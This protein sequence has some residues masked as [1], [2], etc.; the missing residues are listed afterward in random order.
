MRKVV[1]VVLSLALI[2]AA[3]AVFA[4]QPPAG[5]PSGPGQNRFGGGMIGGMMMAC[6]AMAIAPPAAAMIERATNLNLTDDQKTK[7]TEKLTKADATLAPLRQ[8]A[9][10]AATALRTA[11]YAATFDAAKVQ[12]LLTAAQQADAAVST[13]ELAVWTELRAILTADQI[14]QLQQQR[15]GG[16][17][18]G[19]Q[20][21]PGQGQPGQGQPGGRTRGNRNRN[22]QPT[23]GGNGGGG[24]APAQ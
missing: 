24:N 18:G 13:A 9:S 12:T 6:P 16:F 10:E 19:Y 21:Q 8:K 2:A 3:T 1:F 7:L 5:Q 15:R 4:Q 17:G 23:D 20:G 22:N 11:V 14:T